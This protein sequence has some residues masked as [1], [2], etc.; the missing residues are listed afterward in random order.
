MTVFI[1]LNITVNLAMLV[2]WYAKEY[3]GY[4]YKRLFY[5]DHWRSIMFISV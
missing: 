3:H 4:L 2:F 5:L 1:L